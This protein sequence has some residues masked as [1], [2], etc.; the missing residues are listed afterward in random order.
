MRRLNPLFTQL[1]R[2]TATSHP[3]FRGRRAP[4]AM[5]TRRAGRPLDYFVRW[6]GVHRIPADVLWQDRV[7]FT[8]ADVSYTMSLL[9]SPDFPGDPAGRVLAHRRNRAGWR[10]SR[11]LRLSQP[12]APRPPANRYPAGTRAAGATAHRSLT[13]RSTSP[14]GTGPYQRKSARQT[15][16]TSA[17]LT[18]AAPVYR[19]RPGNSTPSPR[20]SEPLL[21]DSVNSAIQALEDGNVDGFPP[22]PG[23]RAAVRLDLAFDLDMHNQRSNARCDYLARHEFLREQRVRLALETGIDRSSTI[24]VPCR[25][26]QPAYSPLMPGSLGYLPDLQWRLQPRPGTTTNCNR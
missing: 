20:P 10:S 24:G 6:T 5:G 16:R 13:T 19:Q 25:T 17:K 2:L 15:A 8:A 7:L 14:I 12:L 21:Y 11:A 23:E 3:D 4:T 9:R 18:C 26:R 1:N 22:R